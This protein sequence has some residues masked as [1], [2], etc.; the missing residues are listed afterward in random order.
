MK[1]S[2]RSKKIIFS[3]AFSAFIT[4]ALLGLYFSPAPTVHAQSTTECQY[5]GDGP[6]PVEGKGRACSTGGPNTNYK[7]PSG[8][9]ELLT[10]LASGLA[11]LTP[12]VIDAVEG[13]SITR[14]NNDL[15]GKLA[16]KYAECAAKCADG[17]GNGQPDPPPGSGESYCGPNPQINRGVC[18]ANC[19]TLSGNIGVTFYGAS[20]S[21]QNYYCKATGSAVFQCDCKELSSTP[22]G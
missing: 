2:K 10:F 21:F 13:A 1:V 9:Q 17:D 14:C 11:P 20:T 8:I 4:L 15:D 16:A 19:Q 7:C 6:T 5:R 18:T 3:F 22:G 12:E